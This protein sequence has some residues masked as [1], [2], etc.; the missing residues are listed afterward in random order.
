MQCTTIQKLSPSPGTDTSRYTATRTKRKPRTT[1]TGH[2]QH[3]KQKTY[4]TYVHSNGKTHQI[5]TNKPTNVNVVKCRKMTSFSLTFQ[6]TF[7]KHQTAQKTH[8]TISTFGVSRP[9]HLNSKI[10][11]HQTPID[12]QSTRISNTKNFSLPKLILLTTERQVQALTD[13]ECLPKTTWL[14]NWFL[15]EQDPISPQHHAHLVKGHLKITVTV[16]L[17]LPKGPHPQKK[18]LRL[19]ELSLTQGFFENSSQFLFRI[20]WP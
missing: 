10:A 6:F 16:P 12:D 17:V 5:S 9:A 14:E 2:T 13:L 20:F 19:A 4:A 15:Q 18:M 8:I 11:W 1:M 7:L 3:V